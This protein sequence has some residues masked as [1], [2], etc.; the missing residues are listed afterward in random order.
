MGP[1]HTDAT[2]NQ[3][4][5][6]SSPTQNL[7]TSTPNNPSTTPLNP[8]DSGVAPQPTVEPPAVSSF[9]QPPVSTASGFVGGNFSDSLP[10]EDSE[11][12]DR[13]SDVPMPV[14]KVLSVRGVE[15]VMMSVALWFTAGSLIFMILMLINGMTSFD[16]LAFPLAL[17]LVSLPIFA[18]FFLRLRKA[19]LQDPKLRMEPSKRRLSQITQILAFITCFF[20]LIAFVYSVLAK[21]G[22]A[23]GASIVKSFLGLLVVLAIAG[24]V[25]VY[26]W[27]DE[28][29][30]AAL[31]G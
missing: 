13:F 5:V 3:P 20:N 23:E 8:T 4:A 1:K 28:H 16:T 9:S 6:S 24:G 31:Q 26:Y 12:F 29:R 19:E 15:Y 10:S 18:L 30:N 2:G 25:L 11:S 7:T 14:I 27:F 22:G 21:F 17:L